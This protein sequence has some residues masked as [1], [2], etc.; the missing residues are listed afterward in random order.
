[1]ESFSSAEREEN[2]HWPELEGTSGSVSYLTLSC[3]APD[4]L[5][6]LEGNASLRSPL[7]PH[8]LRTW[9]LL[10]ANPLSHLVKSQMFSNLIVP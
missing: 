7:H 9:F 4:S 5:S 2:S 6:H 10:I 1:M 3:T 8:S